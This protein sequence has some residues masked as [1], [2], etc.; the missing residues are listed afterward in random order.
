LFRLVVANN[1]LIAAGS[2]DTGKGRFAVKVPGLFE[3]ADDVL[4]RP[5]IRPVS[6]VV[7]VTM[8]QPVM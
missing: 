7:R 3:T 6:F 1:Q 5:E 4:W 2:L 8:I